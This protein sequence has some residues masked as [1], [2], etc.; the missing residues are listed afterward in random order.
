MKKLFFIL[1]CTLIF[2]NCNQ[3]DVVSC[4][5]PPNPF[6]FEIVDKTTGENV[7]T[8]G[9]YNSEDITLTNILSNNDSVE[10]NFIDEDSYNIIEINS[11]GWQTEIVNFELKIEDETI[12]NL[13]V[14]AKRKSENECSFTTYNEIEIQNAEYSLDQEF[15]IYKILVQP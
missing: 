10:F 4:F 6:Y 7:F 8:N 15:Y 5:T 9:T 14:N 12:F 13:Y 3:D 1:S 2:Y 11:I